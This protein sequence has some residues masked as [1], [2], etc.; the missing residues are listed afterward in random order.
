MP[1]RTKSQDAQPSKV[2]DRTAVKAAVFTSV[3]KELAMTLDAASRGKY[4]VLDMGS[5]K[6]GDSILCVFGN[7]TVLIDGGHRSDFAGQSGFDSIPKQ[8]SDALG[9]QSPFKISLLIVTH[10]HAD[11]I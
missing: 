4:Y 6:Y 7:T 5:E 3:V 1:E 8:L 2:Q 11:H 10:C 9:T